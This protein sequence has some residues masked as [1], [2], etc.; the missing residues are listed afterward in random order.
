[1][2]KIVQ[3]PI[4]SQPYNLPATE[5]IFVIQAD[6]RSTDHVLHFC[7]IDLIYLRTVKKSVFSIFTIF[8]HFFL[9]C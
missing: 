8:G 6:M 9:F 2:G 7:M 3:K 5:P 4:T 1:M